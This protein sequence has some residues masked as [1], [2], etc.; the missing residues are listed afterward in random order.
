MKDMFDVSSMQCRINTASD[1]G[2][3]SLWGQLDVRLFAWYPKQLSQR[4][5]IVQ[6][7]GNQNL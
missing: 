2:G 4:E 3:T 1:C 6:P 7:H 5:V